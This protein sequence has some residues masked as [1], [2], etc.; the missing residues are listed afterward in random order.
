M[1]S[2]TERHPAEAIPRDSPEGFRLEPKLNPPLP[3]PMA[4][5]PAC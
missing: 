5:S 3:G 1:E 2:G 4:L